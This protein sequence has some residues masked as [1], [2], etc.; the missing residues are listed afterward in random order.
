[1]VQVVYYERHK[2][3]FANPVLGGYRETETYSENQSF[4]SGVMVVGVGVIM[5]EF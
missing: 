3:R 5:L 2:I 4:C 1:M